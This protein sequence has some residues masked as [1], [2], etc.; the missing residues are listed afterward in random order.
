MA[1]YKNVLDLEILDEVT[2][3]THVIVEDCGAF[4]RVSGDKLGGGGDIKTAIIRSSNYLDAL[5]G[6]LT[7]QPEPKSGSEVFFE[8]INMTFDDAVAIIKSGGVLKIE[9]QFAEQW[10]ETYAFIGGCAYYYFVED[11]Y[12]VPTIEIS[13][14]E[15]LYWT[16][17]GISYYQPQDP[18]GK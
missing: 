13:W 8:C 18:N 17:D 6:T 16:Q 3:N 10:S 7:P 2:E 1:E 12:Y 15:N 4:K 5:N 9:C 14:Y 11:Y